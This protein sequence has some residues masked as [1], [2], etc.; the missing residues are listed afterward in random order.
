MVIFDG[1]QPFE[2]F[3]L[4]HFNSLQDLQN[5]TE[6]FKNLSIYS[7]SIYYQTS[8]F[9][10]G[11]FRRILTEN[12]TWLDSTFWKNGGNYMTSPF[13]LGTLNS[14]PISFIVSGSQKMLL[15]SNGIGINMSPSYSLDISGSVR[16]YQNSLY[17]TSIGSV[18]GII[19]YTRFLSVSGS[20]GVNGQFLKR[21]VS[22]NGWN[23]ILTSDVSGLDTYTS[24]IN[25]FTSS[26]NTS[27][28]SLNSTTASLNSFT[29]SINIYTSSV[30]TSL[31]SKQPQLSGSGFVKATGTTISY[32][33]TSYLPIGGGTLTGV[34][35]LQYGIRVGGTG[36]SDGNTFLGRT[37]FISRTSGTNNTALGANA[38]SSLT[39]G[40]NNVVIGN[41]TGA[42][43]TTGNNNILIGN[44]IG[45]SITTSSN[46]I[47]IGGQLIFNSSN[48]LQL[49]SYT[50]AGFL[51]ND[52]SGNI[53]SDTA[54]IPSL[55]AFTSSINTLTGS[56]FIQNGNSFGTTATLGTNDNN[57]L[58]F[59]TNGVARM[60]ISSS[61]NV[62]IGTTTDT[63]EKFQVNGTSRFIG[64]II[65]NGGGGV[66][67]NTSFGQG[68]LSSN[69]T[70]NS[71]TSFGYNSLASNIT[72][73]SNTAN[74]YLSLGSNTTGTFNSAI[75]TF[76]LQANTTG[77][78]NTAVGQSTLQANTTGVGNT[79][80]GYTSLLNNTTGNSNTAIGYNTG[81][82]ITTGGSNT[83]IGSNV[84]G[85]SATLSNN[86]IIADGDG[87]RRINVDNTGNVGIGTA[88]PSQKLDIQ[89]AGGSTLLNLSANSNTTGYV[90]GQVANA[91]G[92]TY[93]GAD[94]ITGSAFG[95]GAYASVFGAGGTNSLSLITSAL[96]RLNI[97]SGGNVGIG[98]TST[99]RK[100]DVKAS[101]G[102]SQI[103]SFYN[104]DFVFSTVG[105]SLAFST[106]A[107]TGNT[108]FKIQANNSGESAAG[109]LTLNPDGGN[110]GIGTSTNAGYKLNV[111]GGVSNFSDNILLSGGV[112]ANNKIGFNA[113]ATNYYIQGISSGMQ[114]SPYSVGNFTF[115]S[116]NGNWSFTNGNVGIG[117]TAPLAKLDT[118]GDIHV[119]NG[120]GI[121]TRYR[122]GGIIDFT[123]FAESAYADA[124]ITGNT[125]SLFGNNGTGLYV[126]SSGNVGIG[127]TA[128]ISKTHI[129]SNVST[130]NSSVNL[131]SLSSDRND[132]Y[133]GLG[134]VRG[135]NS[136]YLGVSFFTS[137]S[138]TPSE[139]VRIEPNGNL[140]IGTTTPTEK[141]DVFSSGTTSIK[142]GSSTNAN[143][144]GLK[145]GDG[146]G[147]YS[148]LLQR[149]DTGELKLEAGLTSWGGFQT[150]YT[151]GGE[152][153]RISTNG[154][155]SI[156][157]TSNSRTLSVQT[158][159]NDVN[160]E[161]INSRTTGNNYAVTGNSNG[162]GAGLNM[163]GFFQSSGATSNYGL[164]I[165][166]VAETAS[167]YSLYSD[168]PA[169][170][171]FQGNVGIGMTPVSK[172]S[173]SGGSLATTGLGLHFASEL[174]TGR[175]GTY[176][177]SSVSSIHTYFDQRTV[178]LSAGSTSGYVSGISA[179][180]LGGTLFSGTLR[181]LTSSTERM[182]IFSNGRV[183]IGTTTDAG[184][185]L[186]VSGDIR[187]TVFEGTA[188]TPIVLSFNGNQDFHSKGASGTIRFLDSGYANVNLQIEQT[189]N[190]YIRGNLGVG[191]SSTYKGH[192]Y[193]G[194]E[195]ISGGITNAGAK[196]ASLYIQDS[197]AGAYNG[198]TVVF[199]AGQGVGGAIKYELT[200]GSN[201]S[202]GDL[203]FQIRPNT[204]DT[205][206][207]TALQIKST[208]NIGIG[209][210]TPLTKFH[211]KRTGVNGAGLASAAIVATDGKT[212]GDGIGLDFFGH[213][214][215]NNE[216]GYGSFRYSITNPT[217][218]SEA[219]ELSITTWN[220][221]ANTERIKVSSTGNVGIGTTAPTSKLDITT[222]VE[223]L[224][225]SYDA[226][227][228]TYFQQFSN[229]DFI[230]KPT[231]T[232]SVYFGA[233]AAT[234]MARFSATGALTLNSSDNTSFTGTGNVGIGTTAPTSKLQVVGLLEYAT[235][236]LA[237][238]GGLTVGAFY[239]T[240]GVVKVVI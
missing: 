183:G 44:A 87:N 58:I 138:A 76:A 90:L 209:T 29:S 66:Q 223:Q 45:G 122:T 18:G 236:A 125:L 103:A 225:L 232:G 184:Y 59:E 158:T 105:T 82:G 143:F 78:S 15:T 200:D 196:G 186:D 115:T 134:V 41:N 171:Y 72:G 195:A 6:C 11:S 169:Q 33:N 203:S 81:L 240:S 20:T 128:P 12:D 198:G 79:T 181:F 68:S 9:D 170:S 212:I 43:I 222:T 19:D 14:N 145:I 8:Q 172:F 175:T 239:H 218:G 192:I 133:S 23:N 86:I 207:S 93:F 3:Y 160:F 136:T 166:N 163:G 127:T 139:A 52:A 73:N 53:T 116:G 161:S 224:R 102:S 201:F 31:D 113:D 63:G 226:T 135:I 21:T 229:H 165:Y 98:T 178:E 61:G 154:N 57:S 94:N 129:Q 219:S 80:L 36:N 54:T 108:F 56:L 92:T 117:T 131:L 71:N 187:A 199:G 153:M 151:N 104:S 47:N 48:A 215:G 152:R 157:T 119:S 168:S 197:G 89:G 150:F 106:G 185:K 147:T 26:V 130:N 120:S 228:S 121:K 28:T 208:G 25:T 111:V 210:T 193:G 110:V 206:L 230:I 2:S 91:G 40:S 124:A 96:P 55:N 69:T 180:G 190:I 95:L 22:G 188:T 126:N 237:I 155:V 182:R 174:T 114:Y 144:R 32:D 216:Q 164:R 191:T 4:K 35:T 85:L 204:T 70:G 211:I 194:G 60:F 88:S 7:S 214:S 5:C 234:N 112:G 67:S 167:N 221:G 162:I 10:T 177:A 132:Y 50:T 62:G 176:D 220:A 140:G 217:A 189:G 238:T 51:K 231:S 99:I 83:I 30:N 74:G 109:F 142:I 49:P 205:F 64:S 42:S 123:N 84:T 148:S 137:N 107:T 34:L 97:T 173:V 233:F 39:T 24:S 100:F 17:V 235:N 13:S 118:R 213:D 156:G 46:N 75:G 146:T 1:Q 101:S 202:K 179:T 77:N 149:L 38:L 27:L 227:H 65:S 141:L 37:S 159:T 16:V